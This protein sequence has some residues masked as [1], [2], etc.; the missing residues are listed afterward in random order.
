MIDDII[1]LIQYFLVDS[2]V[3]D[4]L[5]KLTSM[6][7]HNVNESRKTNIDIERFNMTTIDCN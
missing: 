1:Q 2:D 4:G 3:R 7:I 6:L 5:L